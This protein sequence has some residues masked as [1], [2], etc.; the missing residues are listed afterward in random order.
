MRI[1]AKQL[2]VEKNDG[3]ANDAFGRSSFGQSL[4]N[5]I[6]HTSDGLVISLDARWG[7]GKT[8]F[9][10]MWQG[11]L[12]ENGLPS[13]YID[14][15]QDDY[16][17]DAFLSLASHIT[18]YAKEHSEFADAAE[19]KAK[20]AK[21]L[22]HLLSWSG[23]VGAKALTLGLIGN[24]EVE[25]L[26]KI[27]GDIAD[28]AASAAEKI[29]LD[30]LSSSQ[31]DAALVSSFRETLSTL[32]S[33]LRDNEGNRLV[34]IIDEL[35][36]CKPTYAVD[37][38]ERI[39]H[40]FAVPNI[41]FV[42]VM[43]KEQL[44]G[45]LKSVYGPNLDARTYLQKFVTVEAT[46]PKRTKDAGAVCDLEVYARKLY[47][48]HELNAW[49]DKDILVSSISLL[50]KAFDLSLRQLERV[51][52][53]VTL[54]YSVSDEHAYR[55]P[56]LISFLCILKVVEP[57]LFQ[58]LASGRLSYEQLT[59]ELQARW[60]NLSNGTEP[61]I[62]R[63]VEVLTFALSNEHEFGNLPTEHGARRFGDSLYRYNM[64]RKDITPY[65]CQQLN[66]FS[67]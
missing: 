38:L 47:S 12:A 32:P 15:F 29:L 46:L 5:L 57:P 1:I 67:A 13:I 37:V 43:N 21:I 64:D 16:A 58:R 23:K 28:S 6:T 34:V 18:A 4:L 11:M 8:T 7:E 45:A 25:S 9:V 52:T 39:K 59:V 51:F 66:M 62:P 31:Q 54:V 20:A 17:N 22:I 19:F 61:R 3:F 41:T 65:L 27:E 10:K 63:I 40:L 42:L 49:G 24:A 26:S 44:E 33:K 2:I 36:R 55:L 60:S 56:V 30:K 48:M 50:A 14:A 53:N 35:D